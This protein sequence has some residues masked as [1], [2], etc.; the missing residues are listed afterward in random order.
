MN[1]VLIGYRATGKTTV[2]KIIADILNIECTDADVEIEARAGKTIAEIFAKDG[3]PAFRDLESEVITDL[4][5]GDRLLL[6]AG[7]GAPMRPEN[8]RVMRENATVV[9]LTASPETIVQRMAADAK[10]ADQ[11]PS[12]TG[13]CPLEEVQEVLS[14][15]EDVYHE[16]AHHTIA[17]DGKTPVQVAQEVAKLFKVDKTSMFTE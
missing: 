4:L 1:L 3:E 12:L 2:A 5:Q 7:G 6:S 17:T 14:A 10:T 8:R 16:T 11:R 15:R 13:K 9:L